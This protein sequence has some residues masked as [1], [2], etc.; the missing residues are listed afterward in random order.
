M[1]Q[2]AVDTLDL[3][4]STASEPIACRMGRAKRNPSL[5][6]NGGRS[7][8]SRFARIAVRTCEIIDG[9]LPNR[10]RKLVLAWADLNQAELT[11]DWQVV[12]N[13]EEL[14]PVNRSSEATTMAPAAKP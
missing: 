8:L 2:P 3:D 9:D 11:A 4:M 10:H 7:G 13:G 6:G 5:S 1:L 12:M 14:S